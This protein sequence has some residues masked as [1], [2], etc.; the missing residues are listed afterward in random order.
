MKN[1]S[2]VFLTE[3]NRCEYIISEN[4]KDVRQVQLD[5]LE[6]FT[7]VCERNNLKFFL[8]GGS[9]IGAIRHQGYIP[10]DD[11]IDLI[12]PRKDFEKLREIAAYEFKEPYFLQTEESDPDIFLGGFA[13]LRN[14]NTTHIE[15]WYMDNPAG[16]LGIWIDICVLDF[17]YENLHDRQ[18]QIQKIRYYQRM[19]YIKTSKNPEKFL[20][21]SSPY[22][23]IL[24]FIALFYS[25]S[26]IR[27]LLHKSLTCCQNSKYVTSF[28]YHTYR[29]FPYTFEVKDFSTF[30]P[31]RFDRL[32]VP[33]P[34]GYDNILRLQY[35]DYMILPPVEKQIPH[36]TGIIDPYIPYK[37]Y[38]LNYEWF[39]NGMAGKIIVVFGAGN[40]LE[41]YLDHEGKNYPPEFAVDNDEKKW[42]TTV[43]GIPVRNPQSIL[44]IPKDN[45]RLLICSIYYREIAKQL[46]EMG[47]D[48]YYI[49]VQNKDWL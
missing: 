25:K 40:M 3:E 5:L 45:L 2:K 4:M 49:Y 38:L 23:R 43:K 31:M 16:N 44:D 27:E 10:W 41:Y 32:T 28:T 30:V 11:D 12:M 18:K 13:R 7:D 37:N 22:L 33:I 34:I 8:S 26:K 17:L 42:G 1:M 29:Y 47:I 35:G 21:I 24:K 46:R 15:P 36:H 9:L 6:K 19:L 48:N 20:E 14:S 39:L